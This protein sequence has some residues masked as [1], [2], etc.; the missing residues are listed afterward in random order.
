MD[1]KLI[2]QL[3]PLIKDM[4]AWNAF[5][6]L[7]NYHEDKTLKVFRGSVTA[8]EALKVAAV[9]K[10]IQELKGQQKLWLDIQKEMK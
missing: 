10:F 2:N 1:E 6:T 4:R 5:I 9:F 7:M 8:E 3:A